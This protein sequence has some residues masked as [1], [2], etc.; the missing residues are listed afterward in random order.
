[1]ESPAL[2][3]KSVR[4]KTLYSAISPGTEL[5][6]ISIDTISNPFPLGYSAVG[7]VEEVGEQ[8]S[9]IQPGDLVACYG[10]PYVFHGEV[11]SVP[12][13]LCA[14]LPEGISPKE[15]AFVGMGAVAIHGIR[16]ADLQFGESVLILGLGILGQI[17]YQV[18]VQASYQ[19]IGTDLRTER[20]E[21]ARESSREP[22]GYVVDLK[23][24]G[25]EKL[26]KMIEQLTGGEGVD[27]VIITAHSLQKSLVNDALKWLR[28]RGKI[29]IVGN[30][31]IEFDREP[32]F[33]KEA[34]LL[35]A[36]AAGPGRYDVNYERNAVDYP[37]GYIRWTEGRNMREY[38]RLLHERKIS[39]SH[40]ITNEYP[41]DR[42]PE[43]YPLI[44]SNPNAL[45]VLFQYTS[46]S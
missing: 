23:G 12:E 46:G 34:D 3:P 22:N 8:V 29:V 20:C 16:K 4:V 32:F 24:D 15:A 45:G 28:F 25:E 39:L 11:L 30:V 17:S 43:V 9:N 35:I 21:L 33:Q 6:L 41:F 19:V 42:A 36:R 44:K 37:F 31:K 2:L 1:M 14:K 26:T 38:V 7:I 5:N 13:T 27:A 10:G 40:L 18:S